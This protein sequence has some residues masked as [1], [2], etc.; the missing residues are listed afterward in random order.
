MGYRDDFYMVQ[1]IIGYSGNLH[2]FPT[3]Y[4]RKGNEYGHITQKHPCPQNVGRMAV[5]S[6]AD[7]W[8]GNEPV[9]GTLKLLE[10]ENGV[11]FHESRST[12]TEVDVFAPGRSRR[13]PAG[14]SPRGCLRIR[15]RRWCTSGA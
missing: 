12:L 8:I 6:S 14:R 1:Y 2:D 15:P 4:F 10:K 3:V 7:Y 13:A 5:R 9:H 11:V